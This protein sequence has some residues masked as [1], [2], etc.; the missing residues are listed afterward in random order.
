MST[1]EVPLVRPTRAYSLPVCGSV[2]PQMS[3]PLPPPIVFSGRCASRSTFWHGY[4]PALPFWQ[5]TAATLAFPRTGATWSFASEW[6]SW[7]PSGVGVGS[8]PVAVGGVTS[9]A[10]AA[11]ARNKHSLCILS[12]NMEIT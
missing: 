7:W 1:N 8:W 3:F 4:S 6:P 5:D 10:M 11:P 12:S 2:Q 9:S